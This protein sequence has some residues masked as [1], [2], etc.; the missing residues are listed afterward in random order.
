MSSR[1]RNAWNA[2][3]GADYLLNEFTTLTADYAYSYSEAPPNPP[4]DAHRVTVGVTFHD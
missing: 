3:V 2:G 4:E 1:S